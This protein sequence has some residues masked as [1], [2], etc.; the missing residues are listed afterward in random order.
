M[1]SSNTKDQKDFSLSIK[2]LLVTVSA[3]GRVLS[4]ENEERAVEL[5]LLRWQLD[6]LVAVLRF[7]G[8]GLLLLRG[9]EESRR[10]LLL[11]ILRRILRHG[12]HHRLLLL[13]AEPWKLIP[14]M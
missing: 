6:G 3:V 1:I 8:G 7:T 4:G 12:H 13:L 14:N 9:A 11:L 5:L 10:H 2:N